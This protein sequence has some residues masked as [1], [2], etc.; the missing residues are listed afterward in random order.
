MK[1]TLLPLAAAFLAS[2]APHSEPT[3]FVGESW[4]DLPPT[5]R[6]EWRRIETRFRQA[7]YP[8]PA[9]GLLH[10]FDRRTIERFLWSSNL[11][12]TGQ[13]HM[14][15]AD[16]GRFRV[17]G[18][19]LDRLSPTDVPRFAGILCGEEPDPHHL[20]IVSVEISGD[21]QEG[22]K[23]MGNNRTVIFRSPK[24]PRARAE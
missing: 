1:A 3:T 21:L 20:K 8:C 15:N 24:A 11:D 16:L 5:P 4:A 13:Y 17:V 18:M 6:P 19:T 9:L 2:C 7:S 23:R 10:D 22:E 12:Q 14:T